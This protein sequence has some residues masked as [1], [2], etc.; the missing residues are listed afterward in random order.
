MIVPDHLIGISQLFAHNSDTQSD[1][2]KMIPPTPTSLTTM[3][4]SKAKIGFSIDSIVGDDVSKSTKD[5]RN[6]FKYINDYQT[7]IAR[8]LRLSSD[9]LNTDGHAKFRPEQNGNT[10]DVRNLFEMP[11]KRESSISPSAPYATQTSLPTDETLLR[12]SRSPSP[13]R[14]SALSDNMN[15]NN[16]SSDLTRCRTDITRCGADLTRNNSNNHTGNDERDV[17]LLNDRR[18]CGA[19]GDD[20]DAPIQAM[21]SNEPVPYFA[22][23]DGPV[24]PVPIAPIPL[25]ET[26]TVPPPPPPP[27]PY[28]GLGAAAASNQHILQAQLQMAAALAQRQAAEQSFPPGVPFRPGPPHH[29][30]NPAA[31][32]REGYPLYPWIFSRHGRMFPHG[33]PGSKCFQDNPIS[34]Y[35][36]NVSACEHTS[37]PL[38]LA[39]HQFALFNA[40]RRFLIN[41]RAESDLHTENIW[42]QLSEKRLYSYLSLNLCRSTAH[43][44]R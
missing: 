3:P 38:S 40:G 25:R 16:C 39:A 21:A 20:D 11:M 34:Q 2:P 28:L 14:S 5:T 24:R 19:R 43:L 7:E 31:M 6:N 4:A 26:K 9:S 23:L 41:I 22:L 36:E 35:S 15:N 30:V 8:A 13:I 33:F 10:K 17:K 1:A 42:K 37:T 44:T 18:R 32:S 29:L 12:R 27:P